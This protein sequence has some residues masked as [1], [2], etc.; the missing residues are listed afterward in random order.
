MENFES[1]ERVRVCA[2]W[3]KEVERGKRS[4]KDSKAKVSKAAVRGGW[5]VV[6]FV[7]AS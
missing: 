2:R 6:S 7:A 5:R 3:D 4:V 1:V